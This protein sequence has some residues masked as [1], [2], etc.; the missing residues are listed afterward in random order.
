MIKK[1]IHNKY[2]FTLK[3]IW[4][5]PRRGAGAMARCFLLFLFVLWIKWFLLLYYLRNYNDNFCYWFFIALFINLLLFLI[6]FQ[7]NLIILTAMLIIILTVVIMIM[8]ITLGYIFNL[9]FRLFVNIKLL[10]I[11]YWLFHWNLLNK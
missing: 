10:L 6:I 9:C 4:F 3:K 1:I 2:F 5:R 11:L 7:G 8:T